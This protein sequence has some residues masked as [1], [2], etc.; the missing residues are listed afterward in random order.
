MGWPQK[1]YLLGFILI[2]S[3]YT[4]LWASYTDRLSFAFATIDPVTFEIKP[5]DLSTESLMQRIGAIKL[6][7][8]GIQIWIA[9]GGWTFNDPGQPT[10][11]T[12][13]AIA[14]SEANQAKFSDSVVKMMNTFSFDGIDIDWEY[15]AADDRSGQ[16]EDFK[17]FVSFMKNLKSTLNRN[18]NKKG[19]SLT[20]PS[21]YWYL[22][23]FDIA[24]LQ[25]HVDWFNLMSYDIHGAWD[26]TNKWTGPHLNAHTNLT[27]IQSALDLI[28][29]N[30]VHPDKVV[31][32]LAFYSRSFTLT[33]PACSEPGCR[34]SSGGNPGKCSKNT[35]V[36]LNPEIQ[37]IIKQKNLAVRVYPK[38]AYKAVSWDNQWVSFDDGP[39]W[40]I[41]ANLA[42]S[43]C[44]S[45]VMVWAISQ[46]D[47]NG[48]NAISLT[49]A[50]GR[51]VQDLPD[52][53]PQASVVVAP[54]VIGLCSWTNCGE[55]CPNGFKEVPRDGTNLLMTDDTGCWAQQSHKFCCPGD[56]IQPKC[57]WRGFRKFRC[58]SRRLQCR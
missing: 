47:K 23:H 22:Q 8:P 16:P 54:K 33:N 12:F 44:M 21:S 5:G 36:L 37:D 56:Y 10:A 32:G 20:L 6:L 39:T 15:P 9:V 40:R 2:S 26:I 11:K 41:K 31:L 49:R 58:M 53:T 48:T 18:G 30:N 57:T 42:R 50:L 45:G 52:F 4:R 34:I 27:E 13:G 24:N 1:R 29:R 19:I 46:D 38:E 55:E 28:W 14:A 17:N 43:Q 35:G 51:T 7:Q 3:P 25:E